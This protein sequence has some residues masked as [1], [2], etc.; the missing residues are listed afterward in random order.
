MLSPGTGLL[1]APSPGGPSVPP[2]PL[3]PVSGGL[4]NRLPFPLAPSQ[5]R[6]G[7]GQAFIHVSTHPFRK[8]VKCHLSG[9]SLF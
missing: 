1:V 5:G 2:L 9:Q 3:F 4:P 6:T 8:D 7:P